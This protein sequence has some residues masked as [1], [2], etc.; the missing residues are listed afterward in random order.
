MKKKIENKQYKKPE[1]VVLTRNKPEETVL[2]ACKVTANPPTSGPSNGSYQCTTQW[3]CYDT[4]N[5]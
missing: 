5:S 2:T 4:G 1:L 3:A